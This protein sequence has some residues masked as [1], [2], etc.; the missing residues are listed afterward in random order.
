MAVIVPLTVSRTGVDIFNSLAPADAAGDE[1]AN[2]GQEFVILSNTGGGSITV[3]LEITATVDGLN[4]VDKTVVVA[5][6]NGQKIIGPFPTGLY[7]NTSTSRAKMTY[8][9]VSGL[10]V[11]AVKC[12]PSN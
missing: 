12:P 5:L 10:Y 7:N 9:G 6:T 11:L 4:P 2:T 3:T 1:W 8:S